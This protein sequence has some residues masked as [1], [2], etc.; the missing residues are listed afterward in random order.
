MLDP[1]L[2]IFLALNLI[3]I[4]SQLFWIW[5]VSDLGAR[6]LPGRP[7][8]APGLE[9]SG[10]YSPSCNLGDLWW[11]HEGGCCIITPG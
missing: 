4:A 11:K 10:V 1:D 7:R 2:L 5:R 6:F 8:R 9:C 3:F